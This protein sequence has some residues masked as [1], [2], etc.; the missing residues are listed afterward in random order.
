[1]PQAATTPDP[2]LWRPFLRLGKYLSADLMDCAERWLFLVSTHGI[3]QTPQQP[4]SEAEW[5]AFYAHCHDG[6]KQAQSEI[7]A[8]LIQALRERGQ[9]QAAQ[10]EHRA[11]KNTAE[12]RRCAAAVRRH[13]LEIA[14]ARRMLDV[15]LWT[16]FAG[17]HS[18]LRR[19]FV[20]GG[21]NSLTAENIRV[22]LAAADLINKDPL[23]IALSCDMLSLVHV[24]D[25]IVCERK[26]GKTYFV[27]LKAGEKNVSISKAADFAVRTECAQFE[28]IATAEYDDADRAHY[29]RVKKQLIRN[30]TILS[31]IRYEG[32][33]D[34][35]TGSEIVIKSTNEPPEFW[36]DRITACYELLGPSKS[37]A[38]DVI[39]D[40]VYLGVYSDPLQAFAAF[41]AWMH[42]QRCES[43]IYSLTHSF[44][45]PALRPLG[46][47][48]LP[49][50]LR[51]KVLRGDVIV[52]MCLDVLK[53][54][55]LANSVEAGHMRLATKAESAQL[56]N[57]Q[58]HFLMHGNR[59]IAMQV[60]KETMFV[61]GGTRDRILFDQQLPSQLIAWRLGDAR[62]AA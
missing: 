7:A 29:K 26:S 9:A 58:M 2:K 12:Q 54:I 34:P 19:L 8:F 4:K 39:D 57:H 14:V 5:L 46:A 35:N 41:R 61:G 37:W 13:D 62:T 56:R 10:Q 3:S 17:E 1:M 60:G 32:G 52:V 55:D 22:A 38:I 48:L 44:R 23:V 27:E 43:P 36:V 33:T 25:L 20:Q 45:D 11:Q 42:I 49:L 40:C 53:F 16:V 21:T 30:N 59:G 24:G 6:W 28:A 15:I 47:A 18:T 51:V 31:T 50:E